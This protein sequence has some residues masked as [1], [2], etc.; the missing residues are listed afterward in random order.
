MRTPRARPPKPRRLSDEA[1]LDRVQEHTFRYFWELAHPVSG[2]IP[3]R[4]EPRPEYGPDAVTTGGSGFGVLALIVGAERG[5][6]TRG[7]VL[8]RLLKMT[9]FLIRADCFHGMLPH[10]M[11][12]ATGR[13]ITFARKDDGGDLVETAFLLMGLLTARRYFDRDAP[14]EAALRADISLLWDQAEWD[15]HLRG[16]RDCLTWHWSPFNGWAVN[17]E[18]RGWNEALIAYV[19]AAASREHAIP[20]NAYHQ[21]WAQSRR[22]LNGRDYYGT[23]LPLG[24]DYGGP[25]YFSHYSFLCLD[26]R[27]LE[28]RYADYW[29][30]N[31]AHTLINREHAVRN[32]P[33]FAGYGPACW[34]LTASE[35][36]SGYGAF[37]PDQDQGVIAPTA[38]LSAFPYTPDLSMAALRH[39]HDGIGAPLFGKYG[40]VDA[41]RPDGSWFATAHL[42][43][44]Q[45]PIIAMIENHRTGL[46]WRLFMGCD[47]VQRG[48]RRL[49]FSS[50]HLQPRAGDEA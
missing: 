39:F 50:P 6:V 13:A 33:G 31:L 29:Q 46:L 34:G 1:L 15:W 41:F 27:G 40:F 18:I 7:E 25:L 38:A 4:S 47:D 44:D 16:D 17:F 35:G 9:R 22:F 45:G 37:A 11:N 36:P 26:P 28:D 24:P 12:G 23:T 3:D 48:L 30:Q 49:G 32:P 2:L 42:A 43:I 19:L 8:A 20:P 21:G 10:M 14:E 5:F